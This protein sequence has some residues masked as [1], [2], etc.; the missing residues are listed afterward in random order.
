MSMKLLET[1][2][3]PLLFSCRHAVISGASA[4]EPHMT[5][6]FLKQGG[7]IDLDFLGNLGSDGIHFR[8]HGTD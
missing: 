2:S 1:S 8:G 5:H 7:K 4:A 3:N 6:I